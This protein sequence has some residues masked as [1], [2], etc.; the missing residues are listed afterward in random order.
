MIAPDP[1]IHR[2]VV[3]AARAAL[4]A[5]PDAPI[6]AIARSAGISRATFYRHFGSRDALLQ[7][8]AH[9]PRPKARMRIL[10]AAQDMLL[11][12]SL[13]DVSMDELAR[14]AD[15]SRGTLYR[16]FPGKAAL[17]EGLIEAYSPLESIRAVLTQHADDA[18]AVVL[19]LL[20]QAIVGVAGARLGLMRA[21]FLE[22]TSGSETAITGMQRTFA[23]ALGALAGYMTTQMAAGRMRR[24]EPFLALQAFIGPI[25]FHLLSRPVVEQLTDVRF[26]VAVAVDE[27][28]RVSLIGLTRSGA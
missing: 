24:M 22:L 25:F 15:V 28:M 23:A 4:A 16:I 7:A 10:A 20:A 18:P 8:V 11:R 21:M 14:A 9:E 27:L 3:A 2:Q 13:G 5:D 26:D 1:T 17:M 6:G 19:P 12:Q